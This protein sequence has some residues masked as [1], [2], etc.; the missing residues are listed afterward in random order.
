MK[1]YIL[2]LFIVVIIYNIYKYITIYNK[3]VIFLKKNLLN[4]LLINND[5]YYKTFYNNDFKVRNINSI[6]D[7][8][9]LIKNS[10]NN[11]T[12]LNKIKIIKCTI[13]A[14]NF[15]N[16]INYEWLNGKKIN[17]LP[18]IFGCIKGK[19]YEQG[20]PHTVN[21]TIIISSEYINK[22]NIYS[23]TKILIHEKIHIYQKKYNNDSKIFINKNNFSIVKKIEEIDNIRANPDIDDN[24]YID[25]NNNIIYKCNYIN[26]PKTISD[27]TYSNKN[28]TSQYY[29]HPLERM[30]IEIERLY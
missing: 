19:L 10:T 25:N 7:Y 11:F 9:P 3:Q 27:V 18:W 12:L 8:F 4:K 5:I 30:A 2:I 1:N 23:L 21:D 29:E 13:N 22:Y 20:L 28:K 26:S 17:N 14:D 16:N 15:F 6:N 24:I